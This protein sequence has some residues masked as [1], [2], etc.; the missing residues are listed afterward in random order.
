MLRQVPGVIIQEEDG[1]GLRPNI[2]M[3]GSGTERSSKITLM[4][5]G[6]LIAPAP[7]AAPAAYYFPVAGRMESIE[8]RKGS[9]QVK[10]GPRTNGGV[11]NLVSTSIPESL[12]LNTSLALGGDASR[13]LH[14]NIGD[15]YGNLAWMFET[16]QFGTD[17]YKEIDGGDSSGYRVQDYLGKI[18]LSSPARW[19]VFQSLE[20]KVGYRTQ[21]SDETYLGLTDGDFESNALRRYAAS[22]PDRIDWDHQ[23]FQLQHFVATNDLDL[24]TTVYRNQ[25]ARNWY[26]LQSVL[27]A[28][29]GSIFEDPILFEENLAIVRGSTS[30]PDDLKVRANNREYFGSGIQSALG[31][32]ANTVGLEHELE[33]GIRYHRDQEDRLQFEDGFQMVD[34]LMALTSQGAPGSQSNRLSEA[35]ASALYVQDEVSFG[36]LTLSPGLRYERIELSRLDYLR[37]DPSRSDGPSRTRTNTLDVVVPGLGARV[38]VSNSLQVFGGIHKGFSPPGPGSDEET[39]AESSLNYELGIRERTERASA[40]VILF[41]NDYRNLLG[42]D[43]LAS[44]GSGEGTLFNGGEV[45]VFGVEA[46]L[47]VDLAQALGTTVSFPMRSVYSYTN[48]EFQNDF[49]SDFEAWGDV[50]AGDRLPY[51]PAHQL[52]VSASAHASAWRV[53]VNAHYNSR[54]RTQAG[55]GVP[56]AAESTDPYFV[57]NAF[58]EHD[59]GDQATLFANV[60]NVGDRRYIVARRPAGARPG[61]PRTLMLGIK[62]RLGR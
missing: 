30:G 5:D 52:F 58:A 45:D 10:F 4:E 41:F 40:E 29:I 3:R 37:T 62:F 56:L 46:S 57:V 60:Q 11:L 35:S 12:R 22:Q 51:L 49:E 59:L 19:S 2:G 25:F 53:G 8:V 15:S 42:A 61:L 43:T 7:Y 24:T 23:Q 9:S 18:R 17:G 50:V 16:Y 48:A 13:R 27:G 28:G 21:G 31:F 26:K 47:E 20:L 6:V 14:T 32:Q 34:G 55:Q 1:Y 38:D 54:M 36:R 44:G 39:E 33:L